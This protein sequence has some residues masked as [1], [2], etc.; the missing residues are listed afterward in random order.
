MLCKPLRYPSVYETEV[1]G[2]EFVK[3]EILRKNRE[4]S[5]KRILLLPC[6]VKEGI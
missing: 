1:H 3:D 5:D 6:R 4:T 2:V